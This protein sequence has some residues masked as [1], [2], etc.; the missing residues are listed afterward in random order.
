MAAKQ[1]TQPALQRI[2]VVGS[3][4]RFLSGIS[5][6]TYRLAETFAT[7]YTTTAI[8]M[9]QLIPTRLYPGKARVGQTLTTLKY[10]MPVFDGVDYY[11]L[12]SI[13]G[14]IAFL[15]RRRPNIVVF[16]WW[17]GTVLHSYIVLALV[18]RLLGA[19]LI[20][21]FHEVLDTGEARLSPVRTYVNLVLPLLLRLASG[22]V[23]H[24]AF[25]QQAL[26]ETYE[27]NRK[28]S[29]VVPHGPYDVYGNANADTTRREAPP[30]C[31]NLLFFGV[32]RPYKGVEDLVKAF[33]D[34]PEDQIEQ[35]WLTI[36]GEPWENWTLPLDMIKTSP[37]RDR[38]TLVT[39]YVAD[40]EVG[41][42]FAGADMVVLPYH[43]SSA[44]GPLHIA[45]N[46]GLPVITTRVGGL[47]EAVEGYKGVRLVEP[48]DSDALRQAILEMSQY[49]GQRFE[50]GNSWQQTLDT[51]GDLIKT[52][53]TK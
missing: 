1:N 44:S 26:A 7:R 41:P 34:I 3:G 9:R 18:A 32:I 2:C 21:E 5:Y 49:K 38:I 13:F 4:T 12:P 53:T 37:Y 51:Y 40:E 23:V 11:W 16:Q 28:P 43:R 50:S 36:V 52:I 30:D 20:V 22:Y 6:Y 25:D 48:H 46:Y 33:N 31:I 39:R 45:M 29:V 17:T 8:L 42:Y 19:R 24:S 10:D 27:T 15:L 14:A 47:T 35:Y